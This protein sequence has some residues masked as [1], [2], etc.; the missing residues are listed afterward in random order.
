MRLYT[1]EEARAMLPRVIPILERLVEATRFMRAH[2]AQVTA[3]NRGVS[4]DGHALGDPW[5]DGGAAERTGRIF[6]EAT[7]LLKQWEIEIKDPDRGLIDFYSDR[8]GETVYL[9]FLLGETDITHWHTLDGGFAGRRL[10]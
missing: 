10:L 8:D 7:A 1:V 6:E 9:C 4:A 2:Q 5:D 3:A